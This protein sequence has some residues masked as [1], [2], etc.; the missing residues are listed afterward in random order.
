MPGKPEGNGRRGRLQP[1]RAPDR[2]KGI[3]LS[4]KARAKLSVPLRDGVGS[5]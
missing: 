5:A 4:V 2:R 3:E 1:E